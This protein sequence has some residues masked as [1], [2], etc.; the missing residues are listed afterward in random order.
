MNLFRMAIALSVLIWVVGSD[1]STVNVPGDQPTIQAGI[2]SAMSGD[3]VLVGSGTFVGLG[4]RGLDFGGKEIVLRSI[5]GPSNTIIDCEFM[6]RALSVTLGETQ[7]EIQGFTIVNGV[8]PGGAGIYVSQSDLTI[9][10][11]HILDCATSGPEDDGG[12]I[13]VRDGPA[14]VSIVRCEIRGNSAFRGGGVCL[15]GTQVSAVFDSTLISGNYAAGSGGGV[16]LRNG[17]ATADFYTST[18]T[19]N[20]ADNGGGGIAMT[21]SGAPL[22]FILSIVSGNDSPGHAGLEI[23]ISSQSYIIAFCMATD[24][25]RSLATFTGPFITN[26]DPKFCNPVSALISP[27][28]G[29]DYTIDSSSALVQSDVCTAGQGWGTYG[30][31]LPGCTVVTEVAISSTESSERKYFYPNVAKR[32]QTP[33]FF[34]LVGTEADV[35]LYSV[36][37]RLVGNQVITK[38]RGID[39]R[40]LSPGVYFA[41]VHTK[42]GTTLHR[43]TLIP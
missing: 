13:L 31:T 37:G 36:S 17:T 7:A 3:T 10:N 15:N 16:C 27:D 6:D 5:S 9:R 8:A 2:D 34:G 24:T 43:L 35:Q 33:T 4:N 41:R 1:A 39:L 22:D 20:L 29:G 21:S 18:V 14:S 25:S 40:F 42:E 23:A 28:A 12:G 38:S 30:H 11:C 19:A 32:N 26:V